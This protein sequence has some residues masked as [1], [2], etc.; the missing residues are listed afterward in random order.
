MENNGSRFSLRDLPLPAKLV[1]TVFLI[2]VGIGY[3][4]GLMQMHFKHAAKGSLMAS[5]TDVVEKFSGQHAPWERADVPADAKTDDKKPTNAAPVKFVAGVKIKS[6]I[7]AR[8]ATCH[9]KDGEKSEIPLENWDDV[10]KLLDPSPEKSKFHKVIA[11]ETEE[12]FNK[13]NM[14]QAFTLKSVVKFE[15]D[16]IDWKELL[17]KHMDLEPAIRAERLTE[18]LAIKLWLEQGA[19][20]SAYEKN[21]FPLSEELAKQPLNQDWKTPAPEMSQKEK[22][23]AA[24]AKRKKNPKDSQLSVESLTQST[25]AHLLSFSMLW[26]LTGLAFAF[27]T[28]PFWMR[29]A[30][31]PIVLVAQVADIGCWWLAR[32]PDIGPYFA[33]AIM[34]TGALVALGLSA[35]I[36]LSLFNMYRGK[37]KVVLLLLA[38]IAVGSGG[39][40]YL[41]YVGPMVALEREGG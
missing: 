41:K 30:V 33:F 15:N 19:P 28:Y 17:K 32:L 2:A 35:Q 23:A 6:I 29:V 24:A 8:C 9:G 11:K 14:T 7:D 38:L 36:L 5:P 16:E 20:E 25:H 10:K 22:A 31:A 37:G 3:F 13:D 18:R 12:N 1:V 4:W 26:A 39:V 40:V 34:G 21:A 27:T